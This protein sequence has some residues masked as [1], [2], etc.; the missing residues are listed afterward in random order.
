[1]DQSSDIIGYSN[2]NNVYESLL[3]AIKWYKLS[4]HYLLNCSHIMIKLCPT[5]WFTKF[6]Q[7]CPKMWGK[8]P[9]NIYIEDFE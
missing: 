5:W 3:K 6:P 8:Q 1:M 7:I 4:R 9:S 2:W